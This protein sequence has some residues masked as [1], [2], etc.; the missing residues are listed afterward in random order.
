[1]KRKNKI[2]III[3]VIQVFLLSSCSD[4]NDYQQFAE[5]FEDTYNRITIDIDSDDA[6]ETMKNLQS[7]EV[8]QKI[9]ELETLLQKVENN[10]PSGKNDEYK[11]FVKWYEGLILLRDSYKKMDKLSD[12]EKVDV[13]GEIIE[14]RYHRKSLN[15]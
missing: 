8:N 1:M 6:L 3:L 10:V 5:E 12:I 2:I 7:L 15:D 14:I 11:R 4:N 13:Y 9:K